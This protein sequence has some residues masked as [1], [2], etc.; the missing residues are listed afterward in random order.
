MLPL[1]INTPTPMVTCDL[2]E[3][4]QPGHEGTRPASNRRTN[5]NK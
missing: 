1:T 4:D 2:V 3:H 5:K